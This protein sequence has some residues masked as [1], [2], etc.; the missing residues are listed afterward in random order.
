MGYT[1]TDRI[2]VVR[3]L[4]GLR[5]RTEKA[6]SWTARYQHPLIFELAK[7]L[8]D[9][10]CDPAV[11]DD[12][13]WDALVWLAHHANHPVDPQVTDLFL[14]AGCRTDLDGCGSISDEHRLRFDQILKEHA[15]WREKQ[16]RL[17][18]EN[19]PTDFPVDW[20]R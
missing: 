20:S 13:G 15:E 3:Y 9:A 18:T 2:S 12:D 10:G 4:G 5:C 19:S 6:L 14:A 8:I 11:R 7:T 16:D 1:E 17:L